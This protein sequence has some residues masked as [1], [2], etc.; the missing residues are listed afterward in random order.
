MFGSKRCGICFLMQSNDQC[1]VLLFPAEQFLLSIACHLR[2][3]LS[4][5]A[6]VGS[7]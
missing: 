5:A 3:S 2:M 7:S 1:G 6:A 4:G